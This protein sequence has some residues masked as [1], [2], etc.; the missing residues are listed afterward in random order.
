MPSSED[1]MQQ[2]IDDKA[3]DDERRRFFRIDDSVHMTLR[4]LSGEEL[5]NRI[6]S[7]E[8]NDENS[9]SLMNGL[10]AIGQQVAAS[11]RRIELKDPD[12]ADYLKALDRKIELIGRAFLAEEADIADQPARAVNLSGGGMAVQSREPMDENAVLEIR[13][14]L[15]PSYTGILT[16]GT[17]VSCRRLPE[18]EADP[19][20]PYLLRIDFSFMRDSDR[21][22]LIR[23]V[24]LKQAEWLRHRREQRENAENGV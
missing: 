3:L 1:D 11:L 22:A 23:H 4:K 17:L 5:D 7:L 2:Q 19:G 6:A 14:L 13:M 20:Y 12:V 10:S 8:Q 24:L 18:D 16:Y 15:L 21:D 9:F